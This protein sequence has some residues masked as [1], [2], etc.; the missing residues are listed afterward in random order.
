MPAMCSRAA[1]LA[2]SIVPVL[3]TNSAMPPG[4]SRAD[5]AGDEV[6]VQAQTERGGGGVGTDDAVREGRVADHQVEAARRGCCGCNP[7]S[8]RGLPDGSSRAMRAVIGSYSTPVRRAAPR[9]ASGSRAKNR[10]VPMPGSSTRPPAKPRCWAA[11]QSA[12]MTG[13]GRVVGVLRR[14]LQGRVFRRRRPRRR[15]RRRSPPIPGGI[16]SRP[17]AESSSGP[18]RSRRSR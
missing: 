5:R 14:A 6:V 18:V 11:R 10:P 3:V 13:S 8:G 12:R 9:R 7:R 16:P 2:L 1:A 17:A 15:G 4:R